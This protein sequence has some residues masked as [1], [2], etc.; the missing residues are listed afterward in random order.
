MLCRYF[1]HILYKA[2]FEILLKYKL[3]ILCNIYDKYK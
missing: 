1:I 3:N 2:L